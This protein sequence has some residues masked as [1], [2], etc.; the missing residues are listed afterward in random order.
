MVH[1]RCRHCTGSCTVERAGRAG[2]LLGEHGAHGLGVA[3]H[4]A[5]G[6][7][8]P[9]AVPRP[10]H[11][12]LLQLRVGH[13]HVSVLHIG[14]P[15]LVLYMKILPRSC[16]TCRCRCDL[17]PE[18]LTSWHMQ[19]HRQQDALYS[20]TNLQLWVWHLWNLPGDL[21]SPEAHMTAF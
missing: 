14:P 4:G 9:L 7:G 18:T 11:L 6:L 2:T 5:H 12:A 19:R 8:A 15:M 1:W 16:F 21:S 17:N 20:L 3:L 13:L 10:L